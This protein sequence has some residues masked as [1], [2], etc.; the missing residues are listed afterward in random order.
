MTLSKSSNIVGWILVGLLA[1][2]FLLAAVGKLTGAQNEMFVG[3]GYPA[4]FAMLIGAFEL[5]GAVGLLIPKLTRFAVLGLT[6]IMFGAAY[7]HLANGEAAQIIRLGIF[8][9]F[10]LAIWLVRGYSF[11]K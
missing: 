4:W 7:T 1:L 5:A 2:G 11:R 9:G 6:I 8:F 10:L 3:W